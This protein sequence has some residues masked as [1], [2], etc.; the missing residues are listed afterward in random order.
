QR[1]RANPQLAYAYALYLSGSDRDD[2]ALAQLNT[3]PAAQWN[4]NMRELAQRLKMQAVIAHAEGLRAAGDEPA[5]EAYLRRQPADTR[6]DLLLADWALA[7]GEYAAAL[8][9]YQRVKRREPNNPDA[10][11]GEIEAYV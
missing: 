1:Q 2:Q 6:I 4:D 8:G 11:L 7:R 3:L 9:D 5:A 10:Q